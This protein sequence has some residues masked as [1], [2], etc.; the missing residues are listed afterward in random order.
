MCDSYF[1]LYY[2][3]V[4]EDPLMG[5]NLLEKLDIPGEIP[6][7]EVELEFFRKLCEQNP[8]FELRDYNPK[9][10][11]KQ[12]CLLESMRRYEAIG[13]ARKVELKG[14]LYILMSK[15]LEN[16]AYHGAPANR[17]I[18][19]TLQYI[20][21]HLKEKI[22][23]GT[24]AD[25]A[26]MSLDHY[27]RMFKQMMGMTPLAYINMKRIKVAELELITTDKSVKEI[28]ESLSF[29]DSSHFINMF[30]RSLGVSPQQYRKGLQA[31]TRGSGGI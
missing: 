22:S 9:T 7:S 23:V 8:G 3:H 24:L 30:R 26:C 1:A 21:R 27:I 4:Y 28:S 29:S 6:G 19:D 12:D 16:A 13:L 25:I 2:L 10:Y 18:G 5:D 14:I 31:G 11:D 20:Q 15:F 17:H